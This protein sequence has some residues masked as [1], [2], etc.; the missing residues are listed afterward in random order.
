MPNLKGKRHMLM[1]KET[2]YTLYRHIPAIA[3]IKYLDWAIWDSYS[4]MV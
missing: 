3:E 2:H 1:E 4:T